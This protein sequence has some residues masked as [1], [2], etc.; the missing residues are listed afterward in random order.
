MQNNQWPLDP[1]YKKRFCVA[2]LTPAE[3]VSMRDQPI[4]WIFVAESPH[5]NEVKEELAELR[6]PLCGKAGQEW[7]KMLEKIFRASALELD[8]ELTAE[9]LENFCIHHGLAVMNAVQYPIDLKIM[10][11]Y[12]EAAD[13]E[14]H[15]GFSKSGGSHYKKQK[16]TFGVEKALKSLE[17]R[18]MHPSL[19]AAP[20]YAL[21][22]DSKW[23]LEQ[24]A[25][26]NAMIAKR[27]QGSLPHPSAWWR[28]GG[29]FRQKAETL[30]N[31]V[32]AKSVM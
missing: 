23:F 12:G 25:I 19:A 21:G 8:P 6:R 10:A 18:L 2:D 13:P 17:A 11:H 26:G 27:H 28:K 24:L 31:G 9:S 14:R 15:L 4:K 30:L 5:V 29:F 1:A 3:R 22:L 16:K 32:F 20:I 7:W